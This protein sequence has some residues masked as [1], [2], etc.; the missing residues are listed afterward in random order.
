MQRIEHRIGQIL[1][2]PV[3][4]PKH[5][6]HEGVKPQLLVFHTG[7]KPTVHG[8]GCLVRAGGQPTVDPLAVRRLG[9]YDPHLI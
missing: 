6:P 8:L 5:L 4:L 7:Q 1:H 9:R 2:E 3:S